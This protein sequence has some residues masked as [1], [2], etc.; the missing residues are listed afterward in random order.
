[1]SKISESSGAQI[2]N[3]CQSR[4]FKKVVDS[5]A[6]KWTAAV[7]VLA[8]EPELEEWQRIA[9]REVHKLAAK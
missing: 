1:V 5:D 6:A 4:Y 8:D 3:V 7:G 2:L 9:Q